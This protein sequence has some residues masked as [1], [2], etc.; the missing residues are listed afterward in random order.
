MSFSVVLVSRKLNSKGQLI[1]VSGLRINYPREN[2]RIYSNEDLRVR[3]SLD[4]IIF[5]RFPHP[6]PAFTRTGEIL[7]HATQ[8]LVHGV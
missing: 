7:V 4:R 2:A 8:I 6:P 3:L 5:G 1:S